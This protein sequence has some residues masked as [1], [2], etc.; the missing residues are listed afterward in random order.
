MCLK[1]LHISICGY[2]P[3]FMVITYEEIKLNKFPIQDIPIKRVRSYT[4]N[5]SKFV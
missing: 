1:L 5:M 4:T 3:W 2:T